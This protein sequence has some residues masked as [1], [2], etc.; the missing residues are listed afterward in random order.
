ME[1]LMRKSSK[2]FVLSGAALALSFATACSNQPDPAQRAVNAANRADQ[3]ASR[4]EAASQKAQ[5][6]AAKAENKRVQKALRV[7]KTLNKIEAEKQRIAKALYTKASI[8]K[9]AAAADKKAQAAKAAAKAEKN[10]A[11]DAQLKS[12]NEKESVERLKRQIFK[13]SAKHAALKDRLDSVQQG[14]KPLTT[15]NVLEDGLGDGRLE[16][17]YSRAVYQP[18]RQTQKALDYMVSEVMPEARKLG[19]NIRQHILD[20]SH[21]LMAAADSMREKFQDFRIEMTEAKA[22]PHGWPSAVYEAEEIKN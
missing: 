16:D 11:A 18:D 5:A 1:G 12:M 21:P 8:Q 3:A 14:D 7:R 4:A 20:A 15:H 22:V 17:G 9:R 2:L 10:A 6:A 13:L 19:V